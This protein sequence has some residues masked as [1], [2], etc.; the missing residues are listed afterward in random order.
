MSPRTA[1]KWQED[2]RTM[3]AALQE[4]HVDL[5]HHTPEAIFDAAVDSLHDCLPSMSVNQALVGFSELVALVGN[6]HA[7]MYPG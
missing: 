2:L 7:S 4:R 1:K 3:H 6:G 5:Y